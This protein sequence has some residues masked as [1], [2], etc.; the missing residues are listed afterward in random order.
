MLIS[1]PTGI[2]LEVCRILGWRDIL[3]V[4]ETCRTLFEIS[5]DRSIWITL[6]HHSPTLLY[7]PILEAPID[8]YTTRELKN[9]VLRNISSTLGWNSSRKPQERTVP[10]GEFPIGQGGRILLPGGRW[11]LTWGSNLADH[12]P[13]YYQAISAYDLDSPELASSIIYKGTY[14]ESDMVLVETFAQTDRTPSGVG[15]AFTVGLIFEDFNEFPPMRFDVLRIEQRGH[16]LEAKLVTSTI[17]S[18][19]CYEQVVDMLGDYIMMS[20]WTSAILH[21]SHCQVK[22]LNWRT[23][24]SNRHALSFFNIIESRADIRILPENKILVIEGSRIAIYGIPE[25][26]WTKP[27]EHEDYPIVQQPIWSASLSPEAQN[28]NMFKSSK[29]SYGPFA[30]RLAFT[31]NDQIYGLVIPHDGRTPALHVLATVPALSSHLTVDFARVIV[32][33]DKIY[34]KPFLSEPKASMLS[35]SWPEEADLAQPMDW[36]PPILHLMYKQFA[37]HRMSVKLGYYRDVVDEVSGRVVIPLYTNQTAI[38]GWSVVEFAH[39]HFLLSSVPSSNLSL[40][41]LVSW[42]AW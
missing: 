30:T 26:R 40:S 4:S 8:T 22:I 3:R 36:V 33:I 20:Y 18:L 15:L 35:F 31:R 23:S 41:P 5:Q 24:S 10:Q 34:S 17:K 29:P 28:F 38:R 32:C 2:I 1:L 37:G 27:S 9:L 12:N 19:S 7:L 13:N 14:P 6:A 11:L 39:P 25:L 42:Y 21:V 16:G